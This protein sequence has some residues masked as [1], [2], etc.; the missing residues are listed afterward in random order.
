MREGPADEGEAACV[1]L[2]VSLWLNHIPTGIEPFPQ[3]ALSIFDEFQG[4][5]TDHG[6]ANCEGS[7][8]VKKMKFLEGELLGLGSASCIPVLPHRFSVPSGTPS[9]SL[10]FGPKW[11]HVLTLPKFDAC[12]SSDGAMHLRFFP[13][14]AHVGPH[15][16]ASQQYIQW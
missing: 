15:Q 1:T 16:R 11:E 14:C 2:H 4:R 10:P 8:P 5:G 12:A 6:D 9:L 3:G 7:G 13:S